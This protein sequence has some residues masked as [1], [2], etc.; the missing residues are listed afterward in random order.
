M[1]TITL[2]NKTSI[3]NGNVIRANS[4][5]CIVPSTLVSGSQYEVVRVDE[6]CNGIYFPGKTGIYDFSTALYWVHEIIPPNST[7][8]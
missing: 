7:R 3:L 1:K 2:N 4:M 5:W 6:L 8:D